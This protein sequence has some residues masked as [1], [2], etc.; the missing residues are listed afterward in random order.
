[1]FIILGNME[2]VIDVSQLRNEG[3]FTFHSRRPPLALDSQRETANPLLL[4]GIIA[5]IRTTTLRYEG[6]L[7]NADQDGSA[8][9]EGVSQRALEN[10][11]NALSS[12][13]DIGLHM[14]DNSGDK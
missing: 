2:N 4:T 9:L 12:Y 11:W 14:E 3:I 7:E 6:D 5:T 8:Q 1:M 13:L 10:L